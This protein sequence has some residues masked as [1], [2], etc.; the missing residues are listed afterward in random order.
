MATLDDGRQAVADLVPVEKSARSPHVPGFGP[1][2]PLGVLGR[3][4]YFS[5]LS[6][7]SLCRAILCAMATLICVGACSVGPEAAP[8]PELPYTFGPRG[9][10]EEACARPDPV[11]PPAD[12]LPSGC[13]VRYVFRPG[14]VEVD[15]Q[16]FNL[17]AAG[18]VV[19]TACISPIQCPA[20]GF[21]PS[22]RSDPPDRARTST[23]RSFRC[24]PTKPEACPRSVAW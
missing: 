24:I 15:L 10:G 4:G 13:V 18:T 8:V 23:R 20:A 9:Y 1:R 19:A 6:T 14:A 5:S 11:R 3:G 12:A 2:P 16:V 21:A 7:A 22:P 17:P